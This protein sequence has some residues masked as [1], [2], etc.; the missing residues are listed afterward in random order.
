MLLKSI[1]FPNQDSSLLASESLIEIFLKTVQNYP[2]KTACV[3]GDSACTYQELDSKSN[4]VAQRLLELNIGA[5]D[6]LGVY[7]PRGIE[8]HAAIL[9]I[10]K[11]GAAYI[12]FDIDTP[13][14][15]IESVLL[16]FNVSFCVTHEFLN[17]RLTPTSFSQTELATN[18]AHNHAQADSLAYIIFTSGSTG[19]PK[20]IPIKHHQIAHLLKSENSQIQ[21]QASDVIYQGFSVSFDMWFE[22]T[23]LGYLAGATLIIADSKI[24]KSVDVL[25]EFLNKHQVTILHAVPSLLAILDVNIPSLRLVNSGGEACN[26]NILDKW[27]SRNLTF[28]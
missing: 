12:P 14:E 16:D 3:F 21:I 26:K 5:G 20:G 27:A 17:E 28:K 13:K 9:G 4:G 23:W 25:H 18:A 2:H 15:R 7:L 8:L 24:S 6:I 1:S 11:A 10:L 19:K 22:E